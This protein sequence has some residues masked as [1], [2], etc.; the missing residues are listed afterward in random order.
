[1]KISLVELKAVLIINFIS[2][3]L[4]SLTKDS[5]IFPVILQVV[6]LILGSVG[7]YLLYRAT[8]IKVALA[9]YI[10]LGLYGLL[11]ETTSIK[12]GFPYTKFEYSEM[13]GYKLSYIVPYTVFLIWPTLVVSTYSLSEFITKN[14]IYKIIATVILLLLLDLVFDPV[15]TGLGFWIWEKPGMYYDVPFLNFMGW[16]FSAIVSTLVVFFFLGKRSLENK[17]LVL[18]YIGN[19]IL[20]TYLNILMGM[21]I[22]P[23]ISILMLIILFKKFKLVS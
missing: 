10:I 20:W 8:N 21:Y 6:L 14:K 1:M 13:M 16:I 19:L 18:I 11:I 5:S 12:T 7:F 15:A 23:I 17:Y 9:I 2:A 3:L 22:P 4:I